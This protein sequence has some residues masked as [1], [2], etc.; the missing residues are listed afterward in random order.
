MREDYHYWLNKLAQYSKNYGIPITICKEDIENANVIDSSQLVS[1]KF[2]DKVE[3]MTTNAPV[4]FKLLRNHAKDKERGM[5]QCDWFQKD[6]SIHVSP[7]IDGPIIILPYKLPAAIES[8]NC[9]TIL[10][11]DE[12]VNCSNVPKSEEPVLQDERIEE[13][14]PPSPDDP[15][16]H[17]LYHHVD[18]EL[19]AQMQGAPL[20][21]KNS[22]DS[23]GQ[24]VSLIKE[25][26]K[27][28]EM[29][30]STQFVEVSNSPE[31]NTKLKQIKQ[32]RAKKS[33]LKNNNVRDTLKSE[34]I[35]CPSFDSKKRND[36]WNEVLSSHQNKNDSRIIPMSEP[37]PL[38]GELTIIVAG[39][40]VVTSPFSKTAKL[41]PTEP[42]QIRQIQKL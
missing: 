13:A 23:P 2:D 33:S 35:N 18:E 28:S 14:E 3:W 22:W 26:P 20:P 34:D 38:E 36:E 1:T 9:E 32:S 16:N 41:A 8:P 6:I 21:K 5:I 7:N 24:L 31:Q 27:A 25:Q 30:Q 29:K 40:N 12:T 15:I 37:S 10:S 17:F 19:M 39:T 4:F 11:E 42:T